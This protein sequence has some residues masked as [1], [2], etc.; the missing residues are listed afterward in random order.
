[1][2]IHRMDRGHAVGARWP[3]PGFLEHHGA[4]LTAS[5]PP[6]RQGYRIWLRPSGRLLPP[7]VG[8]GW[9]GGYLFVSAEPRPPSRFARSA[10]EPTSP[11]RGE[12]TGA[13]R[14]PYAIALPFRGGIFALA[15]ATDSIASTIA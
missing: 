7:L 2:G 6:S 4:E 12:V 1:R 15:R 5:P 3:G 10:R 9:G 14:E 8:E 11:T 13:S